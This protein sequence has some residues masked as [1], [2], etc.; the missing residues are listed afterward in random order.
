MKELL[1][2]LARSLVNNPDVVSVSEEPETDGFVQLTLLVHKDDMGHIIGKSGKIIR[3]IRDLV[4]VLAI[5]QG[6]RVKINVQ[7]HLSP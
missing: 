6:K 3:A 5:K 2:Y 1:S 7:E 4:K